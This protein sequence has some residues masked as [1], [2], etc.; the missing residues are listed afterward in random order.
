MVTG[1][2]G[3]P[4]DWVVGFVVGAEGVRYCSFRPLKAGVVEVWEMCVTHGDLCTPGNT[5]GYGKGPVLQSSAG[6]QTK[7][8]LLFPKGR[9]EA[10]GGSSSSVFSWANMAG[11]P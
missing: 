1:W 10:L 11:C 3:R 9:G 8:V 2:G 6:D 4:G 7:K 5:E